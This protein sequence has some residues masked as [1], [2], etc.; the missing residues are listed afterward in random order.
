MITRGG[1]SSCA[2]GCGFIGSHTINL[3]VKKYPDYNFVNLDIL[4]RCA[5][6]K[7][8]AESL[9]CRLHQHVICQHIFLLRSLSFVWT[10]SFKTVC[11]S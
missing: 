8:T 6:P 11:V 7:N 4:D 10:C 9:L 3:L 5:T 1:V 2:G